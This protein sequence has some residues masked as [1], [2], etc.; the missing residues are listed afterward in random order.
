[1]KLL[2]PWAQLPKEFQRLRARM[3]ARVNL[4]SRPRSSTRFTRCFTNRKHRPRRWRKYSDVT[5]KLRR[6]RADD[7]FLDKVLQSRPN[8]IRVRRPEFARAGFRP[9]PW[10]KSEGP[11]WRGFP[12]DR[13]FPPR[14]ERA[15]G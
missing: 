13:F 12:R 15:T 4:A 7:R 9:S 1:M 2:P 8:I 3:S 5:K 14:K 10:P 6:F 11:P